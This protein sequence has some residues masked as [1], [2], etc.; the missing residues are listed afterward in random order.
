MAFLWASRLFIPRCTRN[1][2]AICQP[3]VKTG[4]SA[5]SASWKI[6]AIRSPRSWV[7]A[8]SD[9]LSMSVPRN[10]ISP[11]GIFAGGMSRMP[12]IAWAVTDLPEP[13]SP[14]TARVSPALSE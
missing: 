5:E 14:R 9:S 1:I 12:M 6:I 13:D 7:L 3:T 10:L 8:S 2:S 4:L 11:C